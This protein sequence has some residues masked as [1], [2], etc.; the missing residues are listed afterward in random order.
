MRYRKDDYSFPRQP[1]E[2][3]HVGEEPVDGIA[4]QEALGVEDMILQE[5]LEELANQEAQEEV[6]AN[7]EALVAELEEEAANHVPEAAW[8]NEED[9]YDSVDHLIELHGH[10]IGMC[11][12]PDQRS[13][14]VISLMFWNILEYMYFCRQ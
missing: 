5:E 3:Q 9:M 12:S 4:N 10:I 14:F 7:Q 6:L 2:P 13:V 8:A 1:G 11:L